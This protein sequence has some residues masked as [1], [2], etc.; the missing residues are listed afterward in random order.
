MNIY[1][2]VMDYSLIVLYSWLGLSV[3]LQPAIY[4]DYWHRKR[5]AVE[6]K[7]EG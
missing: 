7:M 3:V 4:F 2:L 6:K 1:Q 5:T